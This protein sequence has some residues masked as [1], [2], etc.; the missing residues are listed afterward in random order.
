MVSTW[1]RRVVGQLLAQLLALPTVPSELQAHH[2]DIADLQRRMLLSQE[3]SE[4]HSRCPHQS[5]AN[6]TLNRYVV[7]YQNLW[8]HLFGYRVVDVFDPAWGANL[9]ARM[10][11]NSEA[12]VLISLDEFQEL[13]VPGPQG[14][15]LNNT[16]AFLLGWNEVSVPVSHHY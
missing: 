12:G 10:A 1:V 9:T 4:H 6:T 5:Y 11:Q 7:N 13:V 8:D 2:V 14:A 3:F 15:Q 16:E